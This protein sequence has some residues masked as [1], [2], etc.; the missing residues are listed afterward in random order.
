MKT[1]TKTIRLT[2]AEEQIL[3]Q[4]ALELGC[5]VRTSGHPS[6]RVLV[7]DIANGRLQ[8]QPRGN[9]FARKGTPPPPPKVAPP[10][11]PAQG[12]KPRVFRLWAK[13]PPKWWR[14][15]VDACM[16]KEVVMAE[17]KRTL[18]E[19]LAAG[20]VDAGPDLTIPPK[21]FG[22]WRRVPREAVASA[23]AEAVEKPSK[24]GGKA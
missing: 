22:W 19:L 12:D 13:F 11:K 6:W 4:M 5:I 3:E 2:N 1:T 15:G 9:H 24:K 21:W 23:P 7:Q 20:M 8:I 17:S 14:P 18:E 16:P 10:Q